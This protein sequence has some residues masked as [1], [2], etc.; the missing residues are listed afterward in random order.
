MRESSVA[1]YTLSLVENT[2]LPREES[3]AMV[4]GLEFCQV[5]LEVC[6]KLIIHWSLVLVL[7]QQETG[8]VM[9]LSR[10]RCRT[11]TNKTK[12]SEVSGSAHRTILPSANYQ[13]RISFALFIAWS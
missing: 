10:Q 1:G 3:E 13:I 7:D 2:G 6:Q 12:N 5:K 8:D 11:N 4:S 9:Q